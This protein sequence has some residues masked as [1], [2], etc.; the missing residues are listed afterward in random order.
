MKKETFKEALK[1]SL[2]ILP[3]YIVLGIGFGVLLKAK[4]YITAKA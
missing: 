4:G 2:N 1:D 3:G